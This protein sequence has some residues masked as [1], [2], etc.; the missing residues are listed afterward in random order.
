MLCDNVKDFNK[1]YKLQGYANGV[2]TTITRRMGHKIIGN[3]TA[4]RLSSLKEKIQNTTY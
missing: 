3:R 4:C 1:L 2:F